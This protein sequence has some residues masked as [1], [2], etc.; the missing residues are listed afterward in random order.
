M[1]HK[2]REK[3]YIYIPISISLLILFFLIYP[4]YDLILNTTKN[5]NIY[6]LS[7][8]LFFSFFSYF[9]MG[10]SLWESLK[11]MNN[12]IPLKDSVGIAL[13]SSTVNYFVS[14]GGVSGFAVRAHL[15]SKRHVPYSICI[16]SSVVLTALIY[17]VLDAIIFLGFFMQ[18]VKTGE[19][20]GSL[21]EGLI[22]AIL[23]FLLSL[24]FVTIL[25]HHEFRNKWAVR[26]YHLL[27]NFLYIFSKKEIPQED[28]K[29]F[30]SQLNE[31]IIKIHE[32]KYE[33]PKV[34][35]YVALDWISNIL[36]LFFAFKAVSV[37]IS[38]AKLVIGFAF[39]MIMTIIPILP[40]GLGAMEAAMATA[41][42]HMDIAWEKAIVAVLIFRV[43]YYL[44]PSIISIFVYFGLKISEP[45]FRYEKFIKNMG[46][47]HKHKEN[48]NYDI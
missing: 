5:A 8:S 21:I 37:K 25:Y 6:Y 19:F 41:Y 10:L 15:L 36:I 13:V 9:L 7:L 33:L 4:K 1:K 48:I 24:F 2:I 32:R 38:F 46:K 43:F 31:G 18:F 45:K 44:I 22:G 40:G 39:G 17:L 14:S 11:I 28:F 42:F 27:N 23:L 20:T 16:T 35:L 12:Y 3:I 26:I 47:T 29:N 34:V 30:E